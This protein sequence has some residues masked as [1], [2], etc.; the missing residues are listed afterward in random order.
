[1]LAANYHLWHMMEY[2]VE[3]LFFLYPQPVLFAEL[4][5]YP[6]DKQLSNLSLLR[7][8]LKKSVL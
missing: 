4:Y 2:E 1:M 3:P 7:L 6:L 8:I 5:N